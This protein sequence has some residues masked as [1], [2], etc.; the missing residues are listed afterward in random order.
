M[1]PTPNCDSILSLFFFRY[2]FFSLK[3]F[4]S[5]TN[6]RVSPLHVDTPVRS[7]YPPLLKIVQI[8]KGLNTLSRLPVTTLSVYIHFDPIISLIRC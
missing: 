2:I 6:S 4:R 3:R 1:R 8:L 7:F 5:G